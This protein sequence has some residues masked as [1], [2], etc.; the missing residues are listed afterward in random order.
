M[1][2]SWDELDR[3]RPS[4]EWRLPLPPT[5]RRCG[6][7]LTGL[8]D[9]RCPECGTPFSWKEVHKRVGRIWSMTLRLRHANQDATTGLIIVLSGW[10]ALGFAH[11]LGSGFLIGIASILSLIAALFGLILGSQV[12]NLRRIPAW[13][14][15]YVTNPPPNM[16]L[17]SLTMLLALSLFF[18][19]LYWGL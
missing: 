14:R 3:L 15:Q 18:V 13:A 16:Y 7:I 9:L 6:Y 10:F 1:S 17:G 11:L 19:V 8:R 2:M 12:L 5:C 4:G